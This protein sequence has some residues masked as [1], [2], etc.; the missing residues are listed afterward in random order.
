MVQVKSPSTAPGGSYQI[1]AGR[2]DVCACPASQL[3]SSKAPHFSL[4]DP[5][6][7]LLVYLIC[8]QG[9]DP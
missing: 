8:V 4:G 3:T 2:L 6:P 9:L 7:P 1:T 5:P